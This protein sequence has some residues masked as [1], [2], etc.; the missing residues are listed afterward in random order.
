MR[1]RVGFSELLPMWLMRT[2]VSD[3]G[4]TRVKSRCHAVCTTILTGT[5]SSCSSPERDVVLGLEWVHADSSKVVRMAFYLGFTVV[6]WSGRRTCERFFQHR[7]LDSLSA[8]SVSWPPGM[9]LRLASR[10]YVHRAVQRMISPAHTALKSGIHES[11][12][13]LIQALSGSSG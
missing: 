5:P 2:T 10:S 8:D 1:G 12:G 11:E 3:F 6:R 7:F 13:L 9:K 4:A